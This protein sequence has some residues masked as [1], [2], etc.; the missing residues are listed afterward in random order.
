MPPTDPLEPLVLP[1]EL[2]PV[3]PLLPVELLPLPPVELRVSVVPDVEPLPPVPDI[4]PL[5]LPLPVPDTEPL[6]PDPYVPEPELRPVLS[7]AA[8]ARPAESAKT[9]TADRL[10]NPIA[11]S[12]NGFV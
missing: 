12:V 7:H 8:S 10:S 2:L 6:L 5:P 9:K 11:T 4:D 3:D 1:V